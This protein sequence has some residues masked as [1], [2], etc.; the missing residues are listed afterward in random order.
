MCFSQSLTGEKSES[1]PLQKNKDTKS[2]NEKMVRAEL[3]T[4]TLRCK[5]SEHEKTNFMKGNYFHLSV[6]SG[7]Y[8]ASCLGK[9]LIERCKMLYL[10]TIRISLN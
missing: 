5:K 8:L 9:R 4:G 7:I 6:V 10:L 1:E 3:G 2:R